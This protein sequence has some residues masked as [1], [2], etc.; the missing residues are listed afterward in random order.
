[1]NISPYF[2]V[3]EL[4]YILNIFKEKMNSFQFEVKQRKSTFFKENRDFISKEKM[5]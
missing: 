5:L 3:L 4:L 2:I 1:M